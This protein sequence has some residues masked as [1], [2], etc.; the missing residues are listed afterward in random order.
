MEAYWASVALVHATQ[1]VIDDLKVPIETTRRHGELA[2]EISELLSSLDTIT[3]RLAGDPLSEDALRFLRWLGYDT[4][5]I[6][7]APYYENPFVSRNWDLVNLGL[8]NVSTRIGVILQQMQIVYLVEYLKS[9]PADES[10]R[11]E[12]D[13]LKKVFHEVA[14][15]AGLAD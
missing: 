6:E 1:H 11:R 12:L 5:R 9:H 3:A 13:E 4:A 14:R 8:G 10:A 7:E 15:T 2:A